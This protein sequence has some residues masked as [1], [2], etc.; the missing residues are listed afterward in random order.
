[1]LGTVDNYICEHILSEGVTG[2]N[3]LAHLE[4]DETQKYQIKIFFKAHI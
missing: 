3:Y 2:T 1:M 4:G